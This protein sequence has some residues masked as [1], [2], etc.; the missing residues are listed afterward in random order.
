MKR[1][2]I[3]FM[4]LASSLLFIQAQEPFDVATVDYP[5]TRVIDYTSQFGFRTSSKMESTSTLDSTDLQLFPEQSISMLFT[6]EPLAN[7]QNFAPSANLSFIRYRLGIFS[8]K[9]KKD[10]KRYKKGEVVRIYLPLIMLTRFSLNY[11]SLNTVSANDATSFSGSPFT[12]R[13]MPSYTWQVGLENSFTFGSIVDFRGVYFEEEDEFTTDFGMYYSLGIKYSGKGDVRDENGD[14][15]KGNWSLSALLYGFS[16]SEQTQEEL[17]ADSEIES[18]LEFIFKFKLID[19]KISRFNLFAN[20]RYDF[21][22][23]KDS[24]WVFQFGIGN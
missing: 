19:T 21:E 8:F 24:P 23:S 14:V 18:G 17:F 10:K 9:A 2:I 5:T 3:L 16:G 13:L 7:G 12:L 4:L 1:P 6:N 20:A 22:T 11:D 15:Y